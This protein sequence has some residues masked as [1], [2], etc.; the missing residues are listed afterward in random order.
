MHVI[1]GGKPTGVKR[2]W[3]TTE[4]GQLRELASAGIGLPAIAVL[5]E[6]SPKSVERQASRH[7]ISLRT[8]GE[9][10]G[11]IMGEQNRRRLDPELREAVFLG[12]SDPVAAERRSTA[13]GELCP[14]CSLRY[15][16]T[17]SGLCDVC[18]LKR[19][20]AGHRDELA[21]RDSRLEL[22]AARAMKYRARKASR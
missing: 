1:R 8:P 6:R 7:R 10:R 15:V 9:R 5:L 21:V 17:R 12:V 11:L 18:H 3:T 20:A 4:L 22:D 14:G 13:L 19:L 16:N 2:P